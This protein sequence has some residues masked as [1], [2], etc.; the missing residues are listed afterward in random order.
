MKTSVF[1]RASTIALGI[2]LG[3]VAATGAFA[4]DAAPAASDDGIQDIV[5][6]AQRREETVQKSSLTIQ[7]LSSDELA[8]KGV[9]QARDLVQLVPGLQIANGGNQTQTYIRGIGDFSSTALGQSAVAYNFDGVYIGDQVSVSPLF[10]DVSR[11]E[12]LKGPQGTLY[13]R[14]S[15]GGAINIVTNRPTDE[16]GGQISVEFGN[17]DSIRT[18]GAINLPLTETLAVRGAFNYVDRDGYLSDGTDDDKQQ[19][20]RLQL[21][22]KPTERVSILVSGDIEHVGGYGPGAVLLPRQDGTGKFTGAVDPINNAALIAGAGG[23]GGFVRVPGSGIPETAITD[24]HGPISARDNLQRN[25]MAE[26]NV[27]LGFADLTFIPA[28][29]TSNNKYFGNLPGF[30]FIDNEKTHQQSYELRLSKNTDTIK[31]VAG[32]FYLDLDQKVN[33]AAVISSVIPTLTSTIDPKLGTKSYAAFAQ[34]TLSLTDSLRLIAGGRYTHEDRTI[35]GSRVTLATTQDYEGDANFNSFTFRAGAEYDLTPRNM[36]YATVSKGFKSGGFNTFA[37][38]ADR[39]NVY[40]PET[41]YSYTV[42]VRNRFFDNRV[43]FNVEGFYWDYKNSQQSHL[44]FDP[45]GNQQFLTFNAASATSYG[46]DADLAFRPTPNDRFTATVAYLHTK[47][48]DFT[49]AIPVGNYREGS[50]GCPV[51][52]GATEATIDCSGMPLPRAPK[53]SGTAGYQHSF[54]LADGSSIVAGGDMSFGSRRYSAVD[55]IAAEHLK[56][57][58]RFNAN[59]TYNL[60]DDQ[61]SITAFVKN[62][63]NRATYLGGVEAPLSPGYVYTV[64]DAPRTYG[65]RLIGKF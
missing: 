4:Q 42:G 2:V 3:S 18:T 29:R 61:F 25:I 10:Y 24:A 20:G 13:G 12:V 37:P 14:N 5:V 65:I 51:T 16:L 53:W 19:S 50:V 59:L 11:V 49:Y 6:T 41:L 26:I 60:P 56:G 64:V 36:L 47:F 31:A 8:R 35:E 45:L 40:R 28:Y 57:Y 32:I 33:Q 17:Y 30:P 27:D 7:V 23:L 43:Q 21:L 46:V 54:D 1:S 9:T 62:I 22:W 63:G 55:Y 52:L 48:D 44:A 34:A 38:T 15:S 58:V 39:S